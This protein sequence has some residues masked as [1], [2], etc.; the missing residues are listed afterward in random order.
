MV[1]SYLDTNQPNKLDPTS[2][3]VKH[4]TLLSSTHTRVPTKLSAS[5]AFTALYAIIRAGSDMLG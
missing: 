5:F 2:T 3:T 4:L 1:D